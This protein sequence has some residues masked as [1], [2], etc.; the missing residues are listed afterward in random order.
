M[1]AGYSLILLVVH[2]VYIVIY[3]R[4]TGKEY[5]FPDRGQKDINALF[6][7]WRYLV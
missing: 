5:F 6:R 1:I 4:L 3:Q 2:I 7:Q